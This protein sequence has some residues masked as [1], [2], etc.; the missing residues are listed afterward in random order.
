[1]FNATLW[2]DMTKEKKKLID[3]KKQ[4]VYS[5][6]LCSKR[7]KMIM[8]LPAG[9]LKVRMPS[10]YVSFEAILHYKVQIQ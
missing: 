7:A 5:D 2:I 1:M 3:L 10:T 8:F 9:V 4:L 6:F